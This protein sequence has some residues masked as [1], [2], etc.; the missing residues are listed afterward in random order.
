VTDQPFMRAVPPRLARAGRCEEKL[1][2][3]GPADADGA[4][5]FAPAK[6]TS[7]HCGITQGKGAIR[8][9][10]EGTMVVT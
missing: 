6:R 9:I 2:E 1:A 3:T 8:A 4:D 5:V 7:K 10:F